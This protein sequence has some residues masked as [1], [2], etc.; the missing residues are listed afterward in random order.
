M[1]KEYIIEI[2]QLKKEFKGFWALNGISLKIP[3]GKFISILGPNGAGKTT[4]LEILEG[5]QKP[6]FGSIRLFGLEWNSKNEKEIKKRIGLS[7]QE[8]RFIDKLTVFETLQLF[9][10]FNAISK[11]RIIEVLHLLELTEKKDTYTEHLSGGFK[12][13]LVL[14]ISILHEPELLFLDEPTTGLDPEARKNIWNILNRL[15]LEKNKT[16]ILTTHYMEEAEYLSD[17][18]YMMNHGKIIAEGTLNH[19]LKR[20]AKF[21]YLIFYYDSK[22]KISLNQLNQIFKNKYTSDYSIDRNSHK[23]FVYI[24]PNFNL[25]EVIEHYLKLLKSS[26]IKIIDFEFHKSNLNDIFLQLSGEKL[27]EDI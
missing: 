4:L 6:S 3:Q 27:D 26:Y 21:T 11:E 5:L 1:S 16:I 19:L 2:N 7:L 20:Y 13:R 23:I 14:A 8:T 18:I 10:S 15:K 22:S 17:Y 9:A 25:I 12:Q 24:K